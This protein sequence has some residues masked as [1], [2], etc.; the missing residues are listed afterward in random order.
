MN[1]FV[2]K[3]FWLPRILGIFFVAFVSIFALDV[4]DGHSGFWRIVFAL[5]IHLIPSMVLVLVLLVSWKWPKLGGLGYLI[6]G[7]I[8]LLITHGSL[9]FKLP[10]A[11][12]LFLL[13]AML[14]L[15]PNQN[16]A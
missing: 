7:I 3:I 9:V 2:K 15:L 1:N 4:F 13:A 5:V 12:P 10:I 16:S 11:A 14:V 6:L 8:H